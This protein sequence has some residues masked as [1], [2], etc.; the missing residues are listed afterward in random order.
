MHVR[1]YQTGLLTSLADGDLPGNSYNLFTFV[2][3]QFLWEPTPAGTA[4]GYDVGTAVNDIPLLQTGGVLDPDRLAVGSLTGQILY[5]TSAGMGWEDVID[6]APGTDPG[7]FAIPDT[8]V[9][10]TREAITL[11]TG[12]NLTSLVNG[13]RFFFRTGT[14][15]NSG[16]VTISI[17]GLTPVLLLK[18][19]DT[20]VDIDV[21]AG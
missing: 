6:I 21:D 9:G 1:D 14:Q 12:E 20:G 10:G 17:D 15:E 13:M 8:D 3:S 2:D 4:A 7:Y 16:Q 19:R 11:T 18:L 5:R